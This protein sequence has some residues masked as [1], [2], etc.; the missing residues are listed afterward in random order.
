[1]AANKTTKKVT[2]KASSATVKPKASKAVKKVEDNLSGEELIVEN[3]S[4]LTALVGSLNETIDV[5]V[6]KV[7]NMAYHL[8]ATEEVL[9]EVVAST[10]IDLARVNAR[11]RAKIANGTD[12][13]GDPTRSIDVAAA[14]ASP[15]PKFKQ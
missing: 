13:Q 5:L 7:E 9:A 6:Q 8:I 4:T 11:I 1:M 15:L 14:I 12:K 3:I 10:G 2:E